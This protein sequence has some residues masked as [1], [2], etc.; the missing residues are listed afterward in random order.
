MSAPA[1]TKTAR[2]RRLLTP[3]SI[4][5]IGGTE[6]ARVVQQCTLL[7]FAGEIWPVS[8]SRDEVHG[9]QAYARLEDLPYAPDAAFIAIPREPTIE[10]VRLLVEMGAGGAVCFAS[11][12][13]ETGDEGRFLQSELVAAAGDMPIIGPNCYGTLNFIERAALWPDN[14]GAAPCERGVAIISQSGNMGLNFTMQRRAMPLAY[15]L[16]L[17][18]Q[19]QITINDCIEALLEDERVTAIGLHVEG[20]DDIARFSRLAL[21]ALEQGKPIVALKAGRSEKGARAT[22]SHTSTLSGSDRLYDALF[23]RFGVARVHSVPAFIETLK[24][25]DLTGPLPGNRIASLSC[26]GGEA[27]LMADRAEAYGLVFPDLEPAHAARLRATLNDFVDIANPLDYHTF[28][29]GH[30]EEA[31]ATFSAMLSGGF[32][33]A[34]LVLDFPTLERCD[35]SSWYVMLEEFIAS[36]RDNDARAAVLSSLQEGMPEDVARWLRDEGIVTFSG[37]EEG[38]TAVAAAASIGTARAKGTSEPLGDAPALA[39]D[40]ATLNEWD[41][42]ELLRAAGLTTPNGAIVAVPEA[43]RAA[44]GIGYPVVM[45]AVSETLA[46]KSEAGAVL[47]N[48]ANEQDAEAAAHKLAAISDRI[49]VEEMVRDGIAE[50]LIGAVRDPQFGPHIVIGAGGTMVELLRDSRI[51]L[52]PASRAEIETA[53]RSLQCFPLLEGWRG[54][55]AGDTDAAIDAIEAVCRFVEENTDRIEE[56]DINPLI[57]RPNGSGAVAADALIALSDRKKNSR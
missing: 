15:L 10:A 30:R 20:I 48:L 12:F 9:H 17:G 43:V 52:L 31:R 13:A 40:V 37:V 32:D 25:L 21:G 45:K 46:H 53:L 1:N 26:S 38:L 55:P 51:V 28:I 36:A 24:L 5:V 49:L 54:K 6:A 2:L 4:A 47:L 56:I 18:N 42:K 39:G 22:V 27:S 11:G 23:E 29:W 16:T 7:G 41:S 14:H 33:L 34:I 19:A 3:K 50:L 57:V 35:V 8:R 44:D